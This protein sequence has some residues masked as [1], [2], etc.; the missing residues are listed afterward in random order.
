MLK[1]LIQGLKD[2][3]YEINQV[4]NANSIP[5]IFSEFIGDIKLQGQLRKLGNKYTFTGKAECNA[6][7]TCDLSLVEFN[8]LIVADINACFIA[9]S[10]MLKLK[11]KNTNNYN[12]YI[13]S[14]D[15]KYIDLTN[16]VR[17]ELAVNLPMKRVAPQFRDKNFEELYPMYA[18]N[19]KNNNSS[20]KNKKKSE[21]DDRWES[22]RK[23]KFN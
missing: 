23:L 14:E 16:E 6:I 3:V 10:S 5:D 20:N 4:T 9:D 2:G 22:L 18:A 12:E 1:I 7:L 11:D 19:S 13:I 21:I 8:E 15:D 17:E